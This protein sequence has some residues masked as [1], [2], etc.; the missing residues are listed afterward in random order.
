VLVSNTAYQTGFIIYTKICD[1]FIALFSSEAY[2]V[3]KAAVLYQ[4]KNINKAYD[5]VIFVKNKFTIKNYIR[6]I[7]IA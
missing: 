7:Y 2:T 3:N 5:L 4:I 6:I 1:N